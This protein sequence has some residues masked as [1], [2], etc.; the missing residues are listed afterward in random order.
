MTTLVYLAG[1]INGCTDA[2]CLDWRLEARS[3]LGPAFG[4][5]DPMRRDYRG[6][7]IENA[8]QIIAEDY[9]DIA[10]CD[11]V[12]ASVARPTWGTAMELHAAFSMGK[13]IVG[14][15]AGDRPSPWL[16]YH[17]ELVSDLNAAVCLLREQL[18]GDGT[19]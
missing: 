7:E 4:I 15:G 12:L 3:L 16:V 1:P 9:A 17:A 18:P 8:A 19:P 2:E 14:F 11:A 13:R 6:R 5:L 10:Q